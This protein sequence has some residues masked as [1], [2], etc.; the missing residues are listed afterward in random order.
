MAIRRGYPMKKTSCIELY[1]D[2]SLNPTRKL[3]AIAGYQEISFDEA[4]SGG[5]WDLNDGVWYQ[6]DGDLYAVWY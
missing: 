1:D 6:D 2:Y 3:L 5:M 4:Y